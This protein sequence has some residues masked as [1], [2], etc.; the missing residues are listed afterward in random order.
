MIT[1]K[2]S[3]I[4]L[5]GFSLLIINILV[6]FFTWLQWYIGVPAVIL[7]LFGL[8]KLNKNMVAD[9]EVFTISKGT[10]LLIFG[11][12]LA[13][14]LISGVGGAFPQKPD[15]NWRN[16]I[17][18]DLI[19][20][21]WP[22]RY[23][24]GMDSSLTYY[25]AFWL[26]PALIG[27]LAAA[28]LGT[29]AGWI[30]ANAVYALYCALSLF[31]V[32]LLLLSHL[33]AT[34]L[35]R[36]LLVAVIL[37]IFSGMDIIPTILA[38][39]GKANFT[40]GKHL[41]WWTY[42]FNTQLQYSSNSTQLCWVFNQAVPAWLAT[43]LLFHEK[44][45]NHFAFLGGILLPYGPIPFLGLFFIMVL[46]ALLKLL[47][48]ISKHCIPVV[49]KQFFSIPNIVS[50]VV[51][52][53][54]YYLFYSTNSATSGSG[55]GINSLGIMYFVFAIIEFLFFAVLIWRNSYNKDYFLFCVL[56]L[57]LIPIVTLGNEQDF[58]MRAFIPLLFILMVYV[59]DYLLSNI[60]RSKKGR[61]PINMKVIPLIICLAIGA[62]TPFVE[63]RTS[64]DK[65]IQSESK[66]T[67]IFADKYGTLGNKD[68]ERDNFITKNASNTI[69]YQYIA[70]EKH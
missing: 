53:P 66:C 44:K 6:F 69:F 64:L 34:S 22:V 7:L 2:T 3:H 65:I 8:Y 23:A 48:A 4:R 29:Q 20:Y 31:A 58:C 9:E 32:M 19:N 63:Y 13:W 37:I 39:L 24:D 11:I 46:Q 5:F 28:M 50:V 55:F 35:K 27:K 1:I 18:H 40:L 17:L 56:G 15:L 68:L 54:I 10:L 42:E 60:V 38:Q 61:L 12:M 67:S 62:V 43:S 25:F 36:M 21:S 26:V 70:K 30:A 41:E 52:F 47:T 16:A 33:K 57:F 49:V 14:V 51:I 45:M 59:T